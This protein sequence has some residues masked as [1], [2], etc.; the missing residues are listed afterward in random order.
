MRQLLLGVL[1]AMLTACGG[2]SG[3]PRQHIAQQGGGLQLVAGG[4]VRGGRI[5]GQYPLLEI[6]SDL[7]VG[8]GR[9]IPTTSADQYAATLATWFGVNASDLP[10]VAPNIAS[11]AARDLGF[12]A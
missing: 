10:K 1:V 9:F 4:A 7:D 2:G 6:G 8:G 3:P 12:L 11:F 5:Y